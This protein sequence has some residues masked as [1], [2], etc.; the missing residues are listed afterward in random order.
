[1]SIIYTPNRPTEAYYTVSITADAN[2]ADYITTNTGYNEEQFSDALPAL[3]LLMS[4]YSDRHGLERYFE[5]FDDD[6]DMID[7]EEHL[8]IPSGN[9][10]YCHTLID[11]EIMYYDTEGMSHKV[12]IE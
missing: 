9:F 8:D 11:V 12:T 4:E 10:G 1:M 7:I 2:D 5:E 6:P 3:K